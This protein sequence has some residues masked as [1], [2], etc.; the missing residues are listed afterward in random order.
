MYKY[1]TNRKY[2]S[3]KLIYHYIRE[4]F[5]NY[6]DIKDK[7]TKF[8]KVFKHTAYKNYLCTQNRLIC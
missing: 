4:N 5:N 1:F 6:F 7:N 3:V 8:Y 2:I